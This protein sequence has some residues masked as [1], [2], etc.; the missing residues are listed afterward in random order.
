MGRL[1]SADMLRYSRSH[2][3]LLALS[4]A[5]LP[6][7][8]GGGSSS[9]GDTDTDTNATDTPGTGGS[10]GTGDGDGPPAD[11]VDEPEITE[12]PGH[13]LAGPGDGSCVVSTGANGA[14]L[15]RGAVLTPRGIL[16]GGEV[17][18]DAQGSIACVACDC[19][20]EAAATDATVVVCDQAVIS[21]GLINPHDHI[22]F[23]NNVPIGEGPDRYEHR[24]DWRTGAGGHVEL[25]TNSGASADVVRAAEL[26][27]LMSGVTSIAGAGSAPGLVRNLDTNGALEGL[28]AKVADSDTFPLDDANGTTQASGCNYG[29][30]PTQGSSIANLDSYLPHI[31]EGIGQTARNEFTCSAGELGLI[32]PQTALIHGVGL[33]PREIDQMR[34]ADSLLVWSPRSNIVLY[35][36]TAPVTVY[37]HLSVPIALGTDWV[38]SG[39]MNMFRELACADA[40]NTEYLAGH[41]ND[42]ELWKMVTTNAAFAVGAEDGIGLLKVGYAADIAIFRTDASKADHRAIIAGSEAD[43][44]LVMRGGQPLF[45]DTSVMQAL[46][47]GCEAMDVCGRAKTACVQADTGAT[48]ATTQAAIEASYPLF[49][50][51]VPQNEPTCVPS[52]P[53][54][55][56]VI[57]DG[58]SDGDGVANEQDNCPSIFNPVRPLDDRQGDVDQDGY[59]DVCDSCPLNPNNDCDPYPVADIDADGVANGLDNCPDTPNQ[60]QADAD[61]DGHGDVCDDCAVPN[62]GPAGCV[63]T[64]QAVRDPSHPSHPNE[65]DEVRVEGVIVTGIHDDGS[66]FY[67][68]DVAG[69]EYSALFVF[70]GNNADDAQVGDVVSVT[71]TYVERFELTQ[72]EGASFVVTGPGAGLP[73]TAVVVTPAEVANGGPL[74]EVY[75][76]VLV[77]VEGVAIVVTNPDGA[78]DFDEFEI[79]AGLRVDDAAFAA[80]DNLC[81]VGT[82]FDSVTGLLSFSFGNQK[83]LP[84]F[85]D[86]LV[87]P[88]CVPY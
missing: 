20:Q 69:G 87:N 85:A 79:D 80:L 16:R 43:T 41:F 11:I 42:F 84:R 24:H 56:A 61:S 22:T 45:G 6:G 21:P 72:L 53:G 65:G 28:A 18:V 7:C 55:Y 10:E 8:G 23:A 51:G 30:S 3:L 35:G 60:D 74:A 81:A 32:Q 15:L 25:N 76:S 75:E 70:T 27:F 12:C 38:P 34:V 13:P 88:S 40:F 50:C 36:D 48:L 73:V 5:A 77:Q 71:G 68:Q 59:G 67:V 63:S 39:S 19:G 47:P 54:E 57:S 37:D 2:V 26:R 66:G 52:R 58:D 49:F 29:D 83:L 17:L 44:V 64:I 1:Q 46:R 86:D 82:T 62:P 9:G 31:A 78:E 14:T 33:T 4:S